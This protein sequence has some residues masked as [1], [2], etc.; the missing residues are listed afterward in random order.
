MLITIAGIIL[1]PFLLFFSLICIFT[2]YSLFIDLTGPKIGE[3]LKQKEYSCTNSDKIVEYTHQRYPASSFDQDNFDIYLYEDG[4]MY[5]F[6]GGDEAG[7]GFKTGL[8]YFSGVTENRFI[9]KY[10]DYSKIAGEES[11]L[12]KKTLLVNSKYVTRQKYEQ[13]LACVNEN[14]MQNYLVVDNFDY[15]EF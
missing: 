7:E 3:L 6:V 13:I 1:S 12:D 5:V 8:S 9:K 14:N 2:I 11:K 15:Q 10:V 4:Q